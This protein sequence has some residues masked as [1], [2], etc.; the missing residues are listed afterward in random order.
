MEKEPEKT[1]ETEE[2]RDET[3]LRRENEV[4]KQELKA[5]EATL[6]RL[7]KGL[8][9]KENE[10]T[11]LKHAV[12]DAEQKI[13]GFAE[14][15][16]RA[17]NAYKEMLVKTSPGLLAELITGDTIE[18]VDDSVRNAGVLIDK[19]RHEMEAEASRTRIP[20]GAPPRGTVDLAALTPREKIQYAISS[21]SSRS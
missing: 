12:S 11:A 16:S 20:A 5:R 14:V 3:G 1:G 18:E 7:E 21:P 4:L 8:A 17:V 6:D 9:G 10:I 19:V 13:A 15:S 2:G